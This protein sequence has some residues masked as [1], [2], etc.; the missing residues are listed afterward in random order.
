MKMKAGGNG[1]TGGFAS[2]GS[3]VKNGLVRQ[4]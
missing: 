3:L 4:K 1:R 2:P